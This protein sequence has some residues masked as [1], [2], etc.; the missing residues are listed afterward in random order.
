MMRSFL[1]LLTPLLFFSF[2]GCS[3]NENDPLSPEEG[4]MTLKLPVTATGVYYIGLQ[5]LKLVEITDPLMEEG[6]DLSINN[7]T[8]IK[9]NGGSTAPGPVYAKVVNDTEWGDITSAPETVY[10]TDSQYG[11]YI[12]ENWYFYDVNTHTVNPTDASY[13]IRAING[14]Y[15]KFR[16]KAAAFTSRTDGELTLIAD[17]VNAPIS[18]ESAAV[19]GR[20]L[21][22]RLPLI[23]GTPTFYSLKEAKIIEIGEAATSLEWDL[24]SDFVTLY[25]NGGTSGPGAAK[26]TILENVDFDSIKSVPA[27]EYVADD[28][29][30][31]NYAIGDSWYAY[32]VITHELSLKPVIYI[33][34]TADGN[35]AKFE[36]IAADF[37]GQ[38]GGEAVFKYQYVTGTEF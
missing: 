38:S 3:T 9:L 28:T 10:E 27:G 29:S 19:N 2:F 4:G 33:L 7:L 1:I 13:V 32:N 25:S 14:I 16:I 11:Y 15:Y 34:R 35:Y 30:T 5:D 17:E 36:I 31:S 20:V 12:G 24:Q 8:N 6:W 26:A 37:S 22:A 23:G 18:P 21:T